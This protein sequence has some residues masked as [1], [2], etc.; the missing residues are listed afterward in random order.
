MAEVEIHRKDSTKAIINPVERTHTMPPKAGSSSAKATR[1]PKTAGKK[2]KEQEARK[3]RAAEREKAKEQATAQEGGRMGSAAK[4]KGKAKGTKRKITSREFVD[5]DEEGERED[6]GSKEKDG[7]PAKKAKTTAGAGGSGS[8]ERIDEQDGAG[9]G[10]SG[11]GDTIDEQGTAPAG[12]SGS[13]KEGDEQE[14]A[15]AGGS[16]SGERIDEQDGAGAGGSGSGKE[17]DE[18]ETA[19]AGGSGT[20][21]EVDEQ[22]TAGAGGSGSGKDVDEQDGAGAGGSGSGN[23]GGEQ[24]G[25]GKGKQKQ[26]APA[27]PSKT[28][29]ARRVSGAGGKTVRSNKKVDKAIVES[30]SAVQTL[31]D[32]LAARADAAGP[33]IKFQMIA[34]EAHM[35][36]A[37]LYVGGS[38]NGKGCRKVRRSV[39][40]FSLRQFNLRGIDQSVFDDLYNKGKELLTQS[41][42]H[43]III[44]LPGRIV[45]KEKSFPSPTSANPHKVKQ[46][47]LNLEELA[48][49]KEESPEAVIYLVNGA[50]RVEVTQALMKASRESWG[51]LLV[52]ASNVKDSQE[53]KKTLDQIRSLTQL[54]EQ[55]GSWCARVYDLD[56]INASG[57]GEEN[58]VSVLIPHGVN[59]ALWGKQLP[60]LP[61]HRL[62]TQYAKDDKTLEVV[63]H[64]FASKA[65]TH[66]KDTKLT[67]GFM[68]NVA[69]LP[70]TIIIPTLHTMLRATSWLAAPLSV[71][72]PNTEYDPA[73]AQLDFNIFGQPFWEVVKEKSYS[74]NSGFPTPSRLAAQDTHTSSPLVK[75]STPDKWFGIDCHLDSEEEVLR[76]LQTASFYAAVCTS[77]N[78]VKAREFA[79]S[80]KEESKKKSP[81][82]TPPP[83][84]TQLLPEDSP[85]SF[86]SADSTPAPV[87]ATTSTAR[88]PFALRQHHLKKTV[89]KEGD[90]DKEDESEEEDSETPVPFHVTYAALAEALPA[91][92]SLRRSGHS[93]PT[94][95]L[96]LTPRP[97]TTSHP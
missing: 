72:P 2:A 74:G 55:A 90:N 9:A 70:G 66:I 6:G 4:G 57:H 82:V 69:D 59:H 23:T 73:F 91:V 36:L 5:S 79:E 29:R 54:L 26:S 83:T 86:H 97:H 34:S 27:S 3:Q 88:S 13:G 51:K 38:D 78:A 45:N 42:E 30:E 28:K 68:E 63:V 10:G 87:T 22:D 62:V 93:T 75:T 65:H 81:P 40:P 33:A 84:V 64:L 17:G 11:S 14:T 48:K 24:D 41:P 39:I 60:Y 32:M 61:D 44:A 67:L 46:L 35:G 21:K 58:I 15:G 16:G 94:T 76:R 95:A 92:T 31:E 53:K 19:G 8:G 80:R 56:K 89:R 12:G 47:V 50:H 49:L 25:R 1:T 85:Q 71:V 7:P 37:M 20:G 96:T 18:Q 43:A 52:T 77:D